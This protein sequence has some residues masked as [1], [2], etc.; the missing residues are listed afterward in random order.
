MK[1]LFILLCISLV[2]LV[3]ATSDEHTLRKYKHVKDF[4]ASISYTALDIAKKYKLPPAAVLAIAGLESGYGRGYVSQITGNILSLGAFKGDRELPTLYLPYSKSK[5]S[6]LF[7]QKEIQLCN[8]DDLLWKKRPK[9]YKRDYRPIPYA[10]TPKSLELLIYNIQLRDKARKVCLEDFATRW[11][12]KHSKV[13]AF[14]EARIWLDNL[15][16]ENGIDILFNMNTNQEFIAKIGGVPHSFN[17]R[18]SWPKKANLI[19][20]KAGLVELTSD[21]YYNDID[22]DKAWRKTYE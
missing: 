2:I 10:G 19:M 3:D 12:V 15:V 13:K 6:V 9:S 16:K 14:K 21:I 8:S 22:F 4:Y 1:K 20:K 5:K 7:D 17:Y 18:K 11:I